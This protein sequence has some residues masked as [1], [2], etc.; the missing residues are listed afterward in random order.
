MNINRPT[1][2]KNRPATAINTKKENCVIQE[3]V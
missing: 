1:T 3:L 2:A